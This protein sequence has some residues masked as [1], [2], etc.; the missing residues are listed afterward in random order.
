MRRA[1]IALVVSLLISAG[2]GGR[3]IEGPLLGTWTYRSTDEL[4][5]TIAV[6]FNAAGTAAEVLTL[7]NPSSYPTETCSGTPT[8]SG[9]SWT[10]TST[11]LTISGSPTCLGTIACSDCSAAGT[12][13]CNQCAFPMYQFM[14]VGDDPDLPPNSAVTQVAGA[15]QYTLSSDNK[16]LTLD[17]CTQTIALPPLPDA[18]APAGL[19]LWTPTDQLASYT[20][21]RSS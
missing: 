5:R 1:A 15:C 16:T 3:V 19:H 4:V 12:F 17:Q 10:A 11:T 7:G 18:G 14:V 13:D 6:T 2:C 8:L 20:L 9:Y 21:T